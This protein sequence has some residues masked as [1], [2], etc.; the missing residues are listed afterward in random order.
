MNTKLQTLC[1]RLQGRGLCCSTDTSVYLENRGKALSLPKPLWSGVWGCLLCQGWGEAEKR[2]SPDWSQDT[3]SFDLDAA[4]WDLCRPTQNYGPMAMFI[5]WLFSLCM[6]WCSM[7][8][9]IRPLSGSR[10]KIF[11]FSSFQLD[12][13]LGERDA[14]TVLVPTTDLNK[15]GW[16]VSFSSHCTQK[17]SQNIPDASSAIL[18]W[19]HHLEPESVQ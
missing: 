10:L 19:W 8:H 6:P 11:A 3:D 5:G 13:L 7:I 15:D 17:L 2:I 9:F 16:H 1:G 12:I 4:M 14:V 18:F